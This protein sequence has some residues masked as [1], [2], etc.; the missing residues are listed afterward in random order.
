MDASPADQPTAT[1]DPPRRRRSRRT[2]WFGGG[3][4]LAVV[5]VIVIVAVVRASGGTTG[6][7]NQ[8]FTHFPSAG[9]ALITKKTADTYAP[10]TTCRLGLDDTSGDSILRGAN[11]LPQQVGDGPISAALSVNLV[12]YTGPSADSDADKWVQNDCQEWVGLPDTRSIDGIGDRA[13]FLYAT[14]YGTAANINVR[15]RNVVIEVRYGPP[16]TGP[17]PA[18]SE[19][20]GERAVRTMVADVISQLS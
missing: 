16:S 11:W 3:V 13:C 17:G 19:Q 7:G 6:P 5:L 10:G 4:V 9:C 14:K 20:Q 15:T 2:W 12:I 1:D 18:F 8:V